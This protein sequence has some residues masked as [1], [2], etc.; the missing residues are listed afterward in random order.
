[1]KL[2]EFFNHL[3][4]TEAPKKFPEGHYTHTPKAL[5]V[6]PSQDQTLWADAGE[7]PKKFNVTKM[8]IAIYDEGD[9][10]DPYSYGNGGLLVYHNAGTWKMYTDDVTRVQIADYLG[11][12]TK[13]IDFSEQGM[14]SEEY[15]HFDI[16]DKAVAQLIS[17]GAFKLEETTT[18][19]GMS[20]GSLD[21]FRK[22]YR[23]SIGSDDAAVTLRELINVINDDSLWS[24]EFPQLKQFTGIS[25]LSGSRIVTAKKIPGNTADEK[26]QSLVK[27]IDDDNWVNATAKH[28]MR[29]FTLGEDD[30]DTGT[31]PVGKKGKTRRKTGIGDNPYDHNEGEDQTAL[32]NSALWNMK[33]VYQT[34]IAGESLSEDDMFAYG[35]LVQYLEQA[36]MPDHYSKFWDLVVDA[37]N[38]AGGFK[39]QGDE[40]MVDK[41]IA[42]Q[43]KTLYQQF[44]AATANV[45]GV[46]EDE[47]DSWTKVTNALIKKFG[48]NKAEVITD[49]AQI[50]TDSAEEIMKSHGLT[51]QG[52]PEEDEK[53]WFKKYP[54]LEKLNNTSW[55]GRL[56][57]LA[58]EGPD[59]GTPV[60]MEDS[61]DVYGYTWNCKKCGAENEFS[62]S[63]K[64]AQ[65]YI[66]DW[67]R[68][69]EDEIRDD[70]KPG[71]AGEAALTD[72]LSQGEDSGFHY[73]N[74]CVKCG[75]EAKDPYSESINDILRLSGLK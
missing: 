70:Q 56:F 9:D 59:Y 15:M 31:V 26:I 1:M 19:G 35:D 65:Q 4:V 23:K 44:K 6:M 51:Y 48:K 5:A 2:N 36:D 24:D 46:K 29:S 41:N 39:G 21:Q 43:I 33:D 28:L 72:T 16:E 40:I 63:R 50:M 71:E 60:K 66:E 34:L 57:D 17:K 64:D 37:I 69:Y 32:V 47:S 52:D 10:Q 12:P 11:I 27:A 42:P 54:W 58:G 49:Y 67:E 30:M 73:G 3:D 14:Q 25:P 13:D 74:K 75:T 45:K 62:M 22:L 18:E 38:S 53:S 55:M 8:K 68:E 7:L 20:Q 61:N